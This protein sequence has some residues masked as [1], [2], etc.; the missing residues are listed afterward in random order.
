MSPMEL[1]LRFTIS[2]PGVH[3]TIVGT[4]NPAHLRENVEAA[5]RGPLHPDLYEVAKQRFT[6]ARV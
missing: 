3:T 2:H 6:S 1:V 4:A 5:L